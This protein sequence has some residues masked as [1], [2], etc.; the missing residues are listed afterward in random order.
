MYQILTDVLNSFR[1]DYLGISRTTLFALDTIL[2]A[3]IRNIFK[4]EIFEKMLFVK[5]M[6]IINRII[7]KNGWLSSFIIGLKCFKA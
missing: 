4:N 1:T 6:E 3:K 2:R 7:Q 5:K